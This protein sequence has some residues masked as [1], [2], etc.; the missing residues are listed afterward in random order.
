MKIRAIT[1][2]AAL[3]PG[4]HAPAGR[5]PDKPIERSRPGSARRPDAGGRQ[6]QAKPHVVPGGVAALLERLLPGG[7]ELPV[8]A[9]VSFGGGWPALV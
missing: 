5:A 7:P 4:Q 9:S 2:V 6:Y 3:S 1:A 8:L